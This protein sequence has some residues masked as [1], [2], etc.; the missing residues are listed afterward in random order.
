MNKAVILLS[1]YIIG[2]SLTLYMVSKSL[3]YVI[4]L[5]ICFLLIW[6]IATYGFKAFQVRN[7]TCDEN[8]IKTI[9]CPMCKGNG[10]VE[11]KKMECT[12]GWTKDKKD[13]KK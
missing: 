2:S 6:V 8:E 4:I 9:E 11:V 13:G 7:K 10:R 1:L 5:N 12:G 3:I